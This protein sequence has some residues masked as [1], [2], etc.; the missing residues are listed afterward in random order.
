[1]GRTSRHFLPIGV[2]TGLIKADRSA[3]KGLPRLCNVNGMSVVGLVCVLG[4]RMIWNDSVNTL[5]PNGP[6]GIALER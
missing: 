1:M 6:A 2:K 5:V 3:Q 4:K